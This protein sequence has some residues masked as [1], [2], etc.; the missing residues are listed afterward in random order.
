MARVLENLDP[1]KVF[2]YFE[3]ISRIPRGSG[4]EKAVSD[5]MV[6]FAEELGL[7]VKQ[8]EANNI[9]I[10]KPATKGYENAPTVIMQGHLDMVCEKNND[11]QHDF[12]TQG[13]DLYI[14]GDFIR[15]RGTTLGADNGVAIAY[16]M[17]VLADDTIEHPAIEAL[18]TTEEE[19]GMG[20]VAA[21]H[22]EY[23]EG[24]MLI[25][26]DTDNEGEFLVSCAGGAKAL[27][28]LPVSYE[29]MA[30]GTVLYNLK[31]NQLLGGHSGADIHRERANANVLMNR[32]LDAVRMVMPLQLAVL[33]GGTKDN[34]ITREAVATVAIPQ[35]QCEAFETIVADYQ[36]LFTSEYE[37]QD[38]DVKLVAMKVD[39]TVEVLS[40]ELSEKILDMIMIMPHGIMGQSMQI[41]GLVET[42]LNIGVVQ[43]EKEM[44]KMVVSIRSSM[45]TKKENIKRKI[46]T[47][48][49]Y[50]GAKCIL[51]GDYPAWVY[52]S[53]SPLRD[54]AVEVFEEIYGKKPEIKAIHAGL[55]CGFILEKMPGVDMIAFGPNTYDIHSPEERASISS[56]ERVYGYL[57]ALLKD[58][59]N[60]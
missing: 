27:I 16:Q 35:N 19:T 9:Y 13:L 59:K 54:K 33:S 7:W 38:P 43:L 1:Q 11:T 32:V 10:K 40:Q 52:A 56:M 44:L 57:I 17:A 30:E 51:T 8:D 24:K 39:S 60:L 58:M 4:N 28:E 31:I 48:C 6:K 36:G 5:Y 55:E 21:M 53:E 14:D 29:K 49:K 41:E 15:A 34:V 37:A 50:I 20:G 46:D 18:M 22:P 25:N 3:E 2:Y 23:L 12:E 45:P 42:S 26:L 47:V